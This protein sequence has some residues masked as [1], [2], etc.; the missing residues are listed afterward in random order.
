M[1]RKVRRTEYP[2]PISCLL[3]RSNSPETLTLLTNVTASK[4]VQPETAFCGSTSL[5][6]KLDTPV[7]SI[8]FPC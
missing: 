5:C 2:F 8:C 3:P 7:D 4:M 6:R 1:T